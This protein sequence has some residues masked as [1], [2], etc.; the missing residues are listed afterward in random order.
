MKKIS[1]V[2]PLLAALVLAACSNPAD[3]F[4]PAA[5]L[6]QAPQTPDPQQQEEEE[7]WPQI[8]PVDFDVDLEGFEECPKDETYG[9]NWVFIS[10]H[11]VDDERI[12][13]SR[14][15]FTDENFRIK[16]VEFHKSNPNGVH[17]GFTAL[18]EFHYE[19]GAYKCVVY[20]KPG[21]GSEWLT[22]PGCGF[23]YVPEGDDGYFST[24]HLSVS[25][26]ASQKTSISNGEKFREV[27]KY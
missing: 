16:P 10:K 13:G 14:K 27:Y 19:D 20:R 22:V 12:S 8:T 24:H 17:F 23:H 15:W 2:S 11:L 6:P 3:G 21:N 4:N 26:V 5:L 7:K 18:G 1:F 25:R 9:I